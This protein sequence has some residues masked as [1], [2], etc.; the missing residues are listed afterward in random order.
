MH[1][2]VKQRTRGGHSH[3]NYS[4]A[5]TSKKNNSNSP[6]SL[7]TQLI[8]RSVWTQIL[9]ENGTPTDLFLFSRAL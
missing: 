4:A 8:S 1:W 3:K 7:D 2:N 9:I 6:T 5:A